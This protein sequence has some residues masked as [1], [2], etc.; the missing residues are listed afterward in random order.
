[1]AGRLAL[2]AEI[3]GRADDSRAEEG[4]PLAVH[5]DTADEWIGVADEP[6]GIG[7]TAVR[8][9]GRQPWKDRRDLCLH[10]LLRLQELAAVIPK[11]GPL[12]CCWSLLHCEGRGKCR[13]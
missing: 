2:I 6:A 3:F 13:Q 10:L 11:R 5:R 4:G 9:A 12:V 8:R 7:K 1:M